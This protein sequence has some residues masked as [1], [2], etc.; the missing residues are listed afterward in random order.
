MEE[1][2]MIVKI[3][4]TVIGALIAA[5][6]LFYFFKEKDDREGRKIYGTIGAVGFVIFAVMLVLIILALKG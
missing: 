6:G 4:G 1:K 5:A 3:L 2:T